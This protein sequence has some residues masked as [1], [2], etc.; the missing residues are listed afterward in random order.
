MQYNSF[1]YIFTVR[2]FSQVRIAV[3]QSRGQWDNTVTDCV[4]LFCTGPKLLRVTAN[5]ILFVQYQL[6][7]CSS[8]NYS[9]PSRM[10]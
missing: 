6:V 10:N 4:V 5:V 1:V 8:R 2:G 9:A 3:K 7:V